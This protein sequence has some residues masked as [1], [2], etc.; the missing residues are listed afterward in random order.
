M[1]VFKR[2]AIRKSDEMWN[3]SEQRKSIVK[4]LAVKTE[5]GSPRGLG[6]PVRQ[7]KSVPLQDGD[8]FKYQDLFL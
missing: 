5:Q 1:S 8:P 4:K 3:L 6:N 7:S 2:E